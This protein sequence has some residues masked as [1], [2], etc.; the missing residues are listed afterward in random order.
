[1]RKKIRMNENQKLN[2]I[3]KISELIKND[4]DILFA[5]IFGSFAESDEFSDIDIGIYTKD[6]AGIKMEFK[7]ENE[8]EKMVKIPI[9]VRIINNAPISFVYNVLNDKILIKDDEKRADF[10]GQVLK[11]YFDYVH[12]LDEYLKETVCA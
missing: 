4:S 1:M 10:E 9:D 3:D 8:I 2:I 11:N 5:Y 7:L 12:L 6:A